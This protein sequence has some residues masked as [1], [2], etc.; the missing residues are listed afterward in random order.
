MPHGTPLAGWG[1]RR[2][3]DAIAAGR[4]PSG[5]SPGAVAAHCLTIAAQS[6]I[7]SGKTWARSAARRTFQVAVV[8]SSSQLSTRGTPRLGMS[9]VA[10]VQRAG[11]NAPSPLTVA[12][13]AGRPVGSGM[14]TSSSSY[15]RRASST[16]SQAR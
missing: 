3:P 15:S 2:Y 13:A 10:A 11:S 8:G 5:R 14:I 4:L 9:A 12:T 16:S 6:Q 1:R 7:W